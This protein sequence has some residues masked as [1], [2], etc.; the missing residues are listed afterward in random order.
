MIRRI[1]TKK[2]TITVRYVQKRDL[3]HVYNL[4]MSFVDENAFVGIDKKVLKNKYSKK[5]EADLKNKNIVFLVAEH[6]G[7][8]IGRAVLKSH[9]KNSTASHVSDFYIGIDKNY[10]RVGLGRKMLDILFMEGKRKLNTEMVTLEVVS[11]NHPALR[12]YK[13]MGFRTMG[14]IPKGRK[15]GKKYHD[16][17]LM[18]KS[19]V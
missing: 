19:L 11:S 7:R 12:L 13:K 4:E 6:D 16:S 10:R 5:I 1:E 3:S 14:R 18:Y 17:I 15:Y 8:I 2:G 9:D